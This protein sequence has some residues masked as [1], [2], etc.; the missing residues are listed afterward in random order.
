MPFAISDIQFE[1]KLT[2][3]VQSVIKGKLLLPFFDEYC[4]VEIGINLNGSLNVRLSAPD[5]L[6][7]LSKPELLK[8]TFDSIEFEVVDGVFRV[9]LAGELTPLFGAAQG[10]QWPSFHVSELSI[11][12]KGNIHLDGGWLNLREKYQMNFHGFQL[13]ISKLG[14]GNTDD[15]GKWIGFS[16]GVKLIAGMPAGASVEGLR[17]TWYDDGRPIQITLNGVRVNFEV[18]NTLKFAGAVSYRSELQQFRGA[19]KLDLIALRMQLDATAVFGIREGQVYLAIYVAAEFPSGIPLFATGLGIYGMAGL[20]ALNM[21]PNRQPAQPWYELGSTTDWYHGPPEVGVTTLDKWTP[22]LGSIAFGAGVT[23]GTLAD[24]GHT[25]SGRVLLAIVFPGPILLI[26]GSASLLQERTTLDKDANFRAIAVLDGRA[27]TF[28][29]GL[30][31]QYR[32]D[33]DGRLIDI[34]G[35]AEGFFNLNDPNAW[36]IN[37]GLKEPRERRLSAR[38]FKLFD[39]YSYVML[40]AQQLAM[41]AWIGFKRQWQFGPL[42]VAVEAWIDGNARV[43]WKPAHFYGDLWLHGS[44]RL[45][46]FGFSVGL[47]VDARL[48]A[49]V[50]DP[51]YVLGQFSVVIDLPWPLS[52]ISVNIKLEW[53]PQPTP[54]PLPLALKEIAIEHFKASTSWPLPRVAHGATPPLLLPNYDNGEGFFS[55]ASGNTIPSDPNVA[56]VVPLDCRP[57]VTFARNINDDARVGV[58]VQP[59][60]P[61]W[62]RIGDPVRNQGPARIR[63]GLEEVILEKLE[64]NQWK[65]VARKGT[66]A[67]SPDLPAL[68]GS[69]A[70]VP[71]MPGGDGRNVGQTKLFLWSR[72]PFA[73]TRHSGR[74]WDEWFS[75]EYSGYPCQTAAGTGW[76]FENIAPSDRVASP[77]QHPDVTGLSVVSEGWLLIA[78]LSRPLHGLMHAFGIPLRQRADIMLPRPTNL[79]RIAI[80]DSRLFLA[81]DFSGHDAGEG[82]FGGVPGGTPD[83][84]YI[85]IR[86]KDIV[87]VRYYSEVYH[88]V[89]LTSGVAAAI[90]GTYVPSLNQMIFVEWHGRLSTIDLFSNEY[91][92]LGTGYTNPED[93]A[94]NASGTIAYV[95]ERSGNLLKVDLTRNADRANATVISNGM[96]APHQIALDEEGGKAYVVEFGGA[97]RLL[98][99]DLDGPTAGSQ[100]VITSGLSQAVGLLVTQDL[101][102]AYVSEQGDGGRLMRVN[103]ATGAREFVVGN[104]P[105]IFFLRWADVAQNSILTVQRGEASLIRIDLSNPEQRLESMTE[106]LP[107]LPSSVVILPD[108][109]YVICCDQVLVIFSTTLLIPKIS[110]ISGNVLVRHFEDELARWSQTGEVLE[111][112]TNYRLQVVTTMELRG[113]GQLSRYSRFERAREF[114]YF[115]TGGPPGVAMLTPPV[116]SEATPAAGSFVSPLDDLSRYVNRTMPHEV[117]PTPETPISLRLF[118]RS[119]DIGIEFNEN[120]VDLM[121]RL[122]RRDLSVHL[123]DGNGAIRDEQGRRLIL[124]NQWG[125]AEEVTLTDREERWLSVLGSSGCTLIDL[126]SVVRNTTFSAPGEPHLLPASSLCE[127]RLVPA[128]LHDDFGGYTTNAGANGPDGSFEHWQV[129]DDAGSTASSWRINAEDVP[130]DFVLV[131]TTTA[132]ST[133][134]Y[135]NGSD[136]TDYRLTVHLRFSD[137]SVGIVWRYRDPGRHYRFVMDAQAGKRELIL[138]SNGIPTSLAAKPFTPTPGG[139]YEVSVEAVQESLRIYQDG[140]LVFAVENATIDGG[141]VGVHCAGASN[142]RFTDVYVNDLRSSAPIVYRFSFLTSRFRNFADHLGSFEN[143]T[144]RVELPPTANVASLIGAARPVSDPPSDAESRAYDALLAQLP[145]VALSPVVRATRVEQNGSGIAFLIQSPEPL[146]WSRIDLQVLHAPLKSGTY[147]PVTARVLRKSDG[148]GVFIV[149]PLTPGEY[150]LV[151]TYRRDNRAIDGNS[152]VFSEAGNTAPE[153]ATLDIPWE[154]QQ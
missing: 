10:L 6:V 65:P 2:A 133:V 85:E 101:T 148:S 98:R 27:G 107:S 55:A 96:T 97:G 52:D 56:P 70:P 12:S 93:V 8:L 119:Y 153:Q 57:H 61:E 89:T 87:R 130:P 32:Y 35:A 58:N 21:E 71:Q 112:H 49:D 113:E 118:Y 132:T 29:V 41:G 67:N 111:P 62:E 150:R 116:G 1:F 38:L 64:N 139:R 99:I 46:A 80:T 74:A 142:A 106:N 4:D 110:D 45:A 100:V 121:Y 134:V 23:L 24:N 40:N 42:S 13:E 51:F 25:F 129:H 146:D 117:A 33:D 147:T 78:A 26:Q 9:K 90:G 131:Q 47:T 20:F 53:G 37:V 79:V 115:R 103:L 43:S 75:D 77:W 126:G 28:I 86:G 7:T 149:S 140:I 5:G 104:I 63:Y 48:A 141:T 16:G 84:P 17:V 54:P 124:A 108:Y 15:G 136:W 50:F 143:K 91:R 102:T 109:R 73:Y 128:L 135:K 30:D 11:D 44:A 66:T 14:F 145:P 144:W 88:P 105:G 138:M 59:V 82:A 34:H 83:R 18:P 81:Q 114:A 19:L 122:G 151:V 92:V 154:T 31:A 72:T 60:V 36:R 3:P 69:W 22:R 127:A 95:T 123:H 152:E 120:Y 137:G 68:F 76:D 94:V 125:K 39:S